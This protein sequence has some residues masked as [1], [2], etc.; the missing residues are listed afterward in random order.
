MDAK[1]CIIGAG[2]SGIAAAKALKAD[3]R[4]FDMFDPRDR[5]G[6]I[7]A[8]DPAPG[9][10]CAWEGMNLNSPRGWYEFSDQPM[11]D[12]YADFPRRDQVAAYLEGVVDRLGVRP[13][14][15]LGEAVTR[16]ARQGQGWR[17]ETDAG[18]VGEYGAVIVANGHH[19]A[20]NVPVHQGAFDGVALHSR[21]YRSREAFRGKR[22][23]VV[24]VGNSGSQIAVDASLSADQVFL[25]VRRGVWVLPHYV[26]GVRIDRAMPAFLNHLVAA[27]VPGMLAEPMLSLY[28][29]L[30]LGRPQK[31]GMPKPD[32]HFGAALPTVSEN[33]FNRIGDGRIKVKPDVALLDHGEV[34]FADGRREAIDAIIW[35]TGYRTTFPFLADDLF[36]AEG[37]HAPLYYRIF[38]PGQ[39]GLYFMGL[40]QAV[41]WGFVPLFEA[42]ARL[43]AAHLAG[44][45]KL[46][47]SDVMQEAIARNMSQTA[48]RYVD[49]PRSHYLLN[50][51]VFRR[52]CARELRRG[53]RRRDEMQTGAA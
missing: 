44:R 35:C 49:S 2:P 16:V 34:G 28:Y 30:L 13:H 27:Y 24:G 25:S 17:V 7:W 45:Y 8:Y 5:V 14:A 9:R 51:E 39:P 38:H 10:T 33:L 12:D 20:P 40:L 1:V 26:R 31:G 42:Q 11:P 41:G 53:L 36:R 3:G 19:N 50:G 47:S 43:V 21:D 29:R 32:H 18:R 23:L 37:N 15:I 48:R 52:D 4:D 22:V 6:G 46:P